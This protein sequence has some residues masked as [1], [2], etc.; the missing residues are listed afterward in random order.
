MAERVLGPFR[1]TLPRGSFPDGELHDAWDTRS[2]RAVELMD[3]ARLSRRAQDGALLYRSFYE[4][5]EQ[6]TLLRHPAIR[7]AIEHSAKDS[8]DAWYVLEPLEGATLREL[9]EHTKH[10]PW[11][12]GAA[13]LHQLTVGL[14]FAHGRGVVHGNIRPSRI[15]LQKKGRVVLGGFDVAIKT[16]IR[17]NV[18][19]FEGLSDVVDNASYLA[20]ETLRLAEPG[21]RS[22]LFSL[23][24]VGFE[25]LT[26]RTPFDS[27]D[28]IR[29]YARTRHAEPPDPWD[30]AGHLPEALRN[31]IMELLAPTPNGRP[32]SVAEVQV[33]LKDM[34]FAEGVKDVQASLR[35]TFARQQAVFPRDGV[36]GDGRTL[37]IPEV[38]PGRGGKKRKTERRGPVRRG[39]VPGMGQQDDDKPKKSRA[40]TDNFATRRTDQMVP[41]PD[42]GPP[43]P[44]GGGP[45]KRST[46]RYRSTS[47]EAATAQPRRSIALEVL[48]NEGYFEK[49]ARK[50]KNTTQ[51][52]ILLGVALIGA[53]LLVYFFVLGDPAGTQIVDTTAVERSRTEIAAPTD[54]EEAE[55]S[56]EGR[57]AEASPPSSKKRVAT[58]RA[59]KVRVRLKADNPAAAERLARQA[60][61]E[62]PNDPELRYL[63]GEAL[64]RLK[65]PD[66][67][68]KS[69]REGDRLGGRSANKGL[70]LAAELLEGDAK[71]QAALALH[72]EALGIDRTAGALAGVARALIGLERLTE[73]VA[74]LR[75]FVELRPN[76]TRE[77]T[78]LGDLEAGLGRKVAA[79]GHYQRVLRIDPT[80]GPVRRALERLGVATDTPAS[81]QAGPEG[82]TGKKT[83]RDYEIEGDAAFK[84]RQYRRAAAYFTK[85][86]EVSDK[87]DARLVKN[88]ALA[89]HKSG[90][91]REAAQAWSALVKVSPRDGDA[92]FQLGRLLID[93][94]RG[95]D[96]KRAFERA[97]AVDSRRWEAHFELGRIALANRDWSEAARRYRAVLKRNSRNSA[98][99][100]NLG[101]ALMEAGE[102]AGAATAFVQLSRLR[103]RDPAPLLTAAGLF[104]MAKRPQDAAAALAE[105][106]RRGARQACQ[107]Q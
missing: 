28:A 64:Y 56:F 101:K 45:R 96:A 86:L 22:D 82:A 102:T 7:A 46:D 19:A 47:D 88:L 2:N 55:E 39:T 65:Q 30:D 63:L 35:S 38:G 54:D 27:G 15:M 8:M 98:A 103:P 99:M 26:G 66:A 80:N 20:P 6:H 53:L 34:L 92:W 105:A 94:K 58:S 85:A 72:Q 3:V 71:F 60:I 37:S 16:L 77:L 89:L 51:Q 11:L 1:L 79:I 73:A 97:A 69:L 90:Q 59:A 78:L 10:L 18:A 49:T 23:G 42:G 68:L 100:N 62:A 50:S 61:T 67:A 21:P 91:K 44:D 12:Q 17:T 83:A 24:V 40:L 5:I 9:L 36:E 81:T 41:A 104:K 33:R 31:L 106:C 84:G 93:L 14:A 107:P 57:A 32:L 76:A 4:E 13:I 48:A 95:G 29:Q 43:E 87:P 70:I 25:M 75:E 52:F 74:P